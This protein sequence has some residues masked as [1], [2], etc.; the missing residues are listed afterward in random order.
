MLKIIIFSV[1]YILGQCHFD[2]P[3][4]FQNKM[5]HNYNAIRIIKLDGLMDVMN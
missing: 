2:C 4:V 1:H 3:G 5:Q